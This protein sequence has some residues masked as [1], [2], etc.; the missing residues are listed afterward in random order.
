MHR[1]P[2]SPA[3][4]IALPRIPPFAAFASFLSY[5]PHRIVGLWK[6]LGF[7]LG[8]KGTPQDDATEVATPAETLPTHRFFFM[9]VHLPSSFTRPVLQFSFLATGG[10]VVLRSK[11]PRP[12]AWMTAFFF[13][14][15]T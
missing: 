4:V 13:C 11:S 6:F 7:D 10:S 1:P 8:L 3:I 9:T 15:V 12:Y 5:M 2:T 14:R